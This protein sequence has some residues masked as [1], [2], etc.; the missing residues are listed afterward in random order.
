MR[1]TCAGGV[2]GDQVHGAAIL[3]QLAALLCAHARLLLLYT[4]A[5]QMPK[6]AQLYLQG[7]GP[8]ILHLHASCILYLQASASARQC[9]F[10]TANAAGGLPPKN[11]W[12][13]DAGGRVYI[14]H[15]HGPKL[16]KALCVLHHADLDLAL[17]I[18]TSSLMHP[19]RHAGQPDAV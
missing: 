5:L 12:A 18:G 16:D 1:I 10:T 19:S 13:R 11:Q 17:Q 4:H 8:P 15:V 9:P 7:V 6:S 2:C 14:M 3:L